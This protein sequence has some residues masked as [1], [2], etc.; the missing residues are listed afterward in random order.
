M[1]EYT[2]F[3]QTSHADGVKKNKRILDLDYQETSFYDNVCKF[4]VL[5]LNILLLTIMNWPTNRYRRHR[6]QR[7]PAKKYIRSFNTS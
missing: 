6:R 4:T 5:I 7:D 3:C 1:E 2:L